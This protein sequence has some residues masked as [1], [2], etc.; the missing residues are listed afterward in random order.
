LG[1]D[2]FLFAQKEGPGEN[3]DGEAACEEARV[4]TTQRFP[5]VFLLHYASAYAMCELRGAGCPS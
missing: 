2:S 3:P 4:G 1:R 5:M